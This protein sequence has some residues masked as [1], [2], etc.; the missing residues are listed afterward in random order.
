MVE[1]DAYG[2][3]LGAVLMQ[4]GRP[5]AFQNEAFKGWCLH[6]ST[7][8]KEFLA[9]VKAIKKWRPYLVGKPFVIK[10]D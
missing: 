8:E 5:L 9:V 7:Y 3:G 10:T 2:V 4:E 6:L 1:R